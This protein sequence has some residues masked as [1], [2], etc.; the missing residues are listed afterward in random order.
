MR[1]ARSGLLIALL[2]ASSIVGAVPAVVAGDLCFDAADGGEPDFDDPIIIGRSFT[3]PKKNK[4]KAFH[5]VLASVESAVTGTA[6]TSADGA[7]TNFTLTATRVIREPSSPAA[8]AYYTMSV[9]PAAGTGWL[10]RFQTFDGSNQ[11]VGTLAV[12]ECKKQYP[13][14]L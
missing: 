10:S 7:Y 3:L 11:Y 8:I 9:D 12:S 13:N 6:C 5:G 1:T 14:N 2:V 4:C